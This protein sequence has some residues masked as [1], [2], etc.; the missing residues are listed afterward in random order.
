MAE[1]AESSFL[2]DL[3]KQLDKRWPKKA[4]DSGDGFEFARFP[5]LDPTAVV[6]AASGS[7]TSAQCGQAE[8]AVATCDRVYIYSFDEELEPRIAWTF[9]HPAILSLCVL[10]HR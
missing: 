3:Q 4:P 8:L 10:K 7:F 1:V 6:A 2:E 5:L 9:R